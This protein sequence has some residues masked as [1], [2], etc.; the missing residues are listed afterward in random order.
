MAKRIL[1]LTL[2]VLLLTGPAAPAALADGGTPAPEAAQAAEAAEPAPEA[3]EDTGQPAPTP[4]MDGWTELD[5]QTY[6][7]IAGEHA[8]GWQTIS[9]K[10]YYFH[11]D[12]R[13]ASG[14]TR[15]KG[16]RYY[17]GADGLAYTGP[18]FVPGSGEVYLFSATGV[19]QKGGTAAVYGRE[20][21]L[22]PQGVLEG[23]LNGTSL[24]AASVLD[25]IGWDLRAAFNWCAGLTYRDR[26][27]R[28]P[29]D[30]VHSEWYATYGFTYR[31]GNCYVMAA[32]FYQMAR[33]LGYD[34]YYIEGGVGSYSGAVVDHSWTEI[35]IDGNLFVFDPDFTNEEGVDGYQIWYEKPGTW[36]YYEPVRVP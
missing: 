11:M 15:I 32:T 4:P 13:R 28:A 20:Y 12:G 36:W 5:G 33:L 30:A 34:A 9:G 17:F 2:L 25:Q 8:T 18:R 26:D 23:Y 24:M 22:S 1:C 7:Y 3:A 6:Y 14:W 27:L 35:V 31:F 16:R 10:R 21:P 29:E 19:L